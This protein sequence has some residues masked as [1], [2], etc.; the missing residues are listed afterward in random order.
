MHGSKKLL[1]KELHP[2]RSLSA[3]HPD[4]GCTGTP[5]WLA[6]ACADPNRK[7]KAKTRLMGLE[8]LGMTRKKSRPFWSARTTTE[9]VRRLEL[10]SAVRTF[11]GMTRPRTRL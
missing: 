5:A 1:P 11:Q 10:G 7:I 4:D 6:V 3:E 9:Q 8:T 2:P